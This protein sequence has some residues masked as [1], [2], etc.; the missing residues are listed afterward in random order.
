VVQGAWSRASASHRRELRLE[1]GVWRRGGQEAGGR[2]SAEGWRPGVTAGTCA[3]RGRPEKGP[4]G[5][6]PPPALCCRA[7]GQSR[8]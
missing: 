7:R 6:A 4:P 3:E 8:D 2:A 1:Q 5:S